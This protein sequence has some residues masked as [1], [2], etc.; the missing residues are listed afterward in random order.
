MQVNDGR[1][2]PNFFTQ[3]IRGA[4]LTVYGDGSQTRSIIYVDDLVEGIWRLLNSSYVGPM[5]IG[6]QAEVSM[7][8]LA[9]RI[10]ALC[11]GKS[12]IVHRPLPPDDPKSR[13]PDTAGAPRA[14]LGAPRCCGGGP[15]AHARLLLRGARR[16]PR[17]RLGSVRAIPTS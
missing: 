10:N 6:S 2:I 13:R 8:E 15:A 17:E 7:L 16:D 14:R 4:D 1:A 12:A 9:K 11:S 5:N 3:A